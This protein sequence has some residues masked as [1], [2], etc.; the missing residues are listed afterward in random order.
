MKRICLLGASGSIGTQALD[1]MKK[2]PVDFSLVGFSVGNRVEKVSEIINEFSP[3]FVCVKKENKEL[4]KQY[5]NVTFYFGDEGLNE[6]I[7]ACDCD[8]VVNALVG[9]VGLKPSIV[10]LENN[11]VLALANKETLVTGG[12][13][14]NK[15]LKDGHG[16]LVPI[17]SE[18]AALSKCLLIQSDN[19]D[20]LVI[21]A[22]GG[23]F[24]KLSR[25]QLE[26]V[27]PE[28]ALKHPTWSMGNKITIDSASMVNK[29]FEIIEAYYLFGYKYEQIELMFNY[30]SFVHSLVKYN[31]GSY[32]LDEGKPDMRVP[33]KY[34]MFEGACEY[35]IVYIQ[36]IEDYKKSSLYD[37]D[38][39][40]FPIVNLA[41]RVIDEKGLLGA[42]F[43]AANEE[44]VYAFLDK[45]IKFTDIEKIIYFCVD[46]VSNI[47]NPS[48]EEIKKC[49]VSIRETVHKIVKG[50][51]NL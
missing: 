25:E 16:K 35:D 40:R 46:N 50:E 17:D 26:S 29:T 2:H 49:D 21:T 8:M 34:A 20:K 27:T 42:A 3:K 5:P 32:R 4:V 31:D 44:A 19:V 14:I 24:R 15:L 30:E 51:V 39:E 28:D 38:Y 23:A 33:I 7:K 22:S 41:K 37:F 43:N 11:K 45:K 12:E 1:V 18:H 13:L 48:Y 6:L 47:Q 36:H 9:F 10:A